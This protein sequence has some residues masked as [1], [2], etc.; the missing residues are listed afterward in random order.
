MPTLQWIGKEKVVSH[1]HDVTF[2]TLE[3]QYGF[4]VDDPDD[5]SET[6]SGNKI[7]HGDNLEALKALL[8]EYEGRVDCVYIDPPYNTGNEKWVYNDNVNDP[9][10]R[11]WLNLVVGAE[12]EDL[13]RHDKWLCMMYPRLTLLRQLLS[14]DGAIFVSIGDDESAHLRL[15]MDE[16]FGRQCFVGDIIWQKA[17]SPRNDAKGIPTEA[18]HLM[19]F[20]KRP[21]WQPNKL[22]R[23]CHGP[24][25]MLSLPMPPPTRGWYMPSNTPSRASCSIPIRALTGA[26]IKTRC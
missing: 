23:Q 17:Y 5:T 18:E 14:N 21:G 20:S 15:V 2:R 12:G 16:I 3:H 1:H 19:V 11:R 24:V 13:S 25:L 9:Q 26:M 4:R 7:I 6:F 22:E 8:P 10:I